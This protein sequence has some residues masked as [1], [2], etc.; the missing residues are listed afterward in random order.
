MYILDLRK[1]IEGDI[2][3]TAQT[4]VISKTIR[5]VSSSDF[6]HAILYVG[7]GSYIHSNGG[8]VHSG[9]TQRLLF[10]KL[11]H[12]QVLRPNNET[13]AEKACIY[14]RTQVGKEYSV[15]DAINSKNPLPKKKES[16][17]QFCSRLV[18]QSYEY[19][20]L[21][22]VDNS[23]YCTPQDI[24]N[25]SDISIVKNILSKASKEEISFSKSENPLQRQAD[26]TNKILKSIRKLTGCDIQSFDELSQFVI[27]NPIYDHGITSIIERSGYLSMWQDEMEKNPWRYNGELFLSM[28]MRIEEKR[29]QASFELKSAHKQ[30]NLYSYNYNMM[31]QNL[32]A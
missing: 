15:K 6:S 8:G 17:R 2:L 7:D 31:Q 3:L 9:N 27:N 24:H 20:G 19:A 12:V 23:S 13:F 14:A 11:K 10:H 29:Q 28:P 32:I 18:A 26:I 16:N 1:L 5:V 4:A 25:S 21:K 22:L 30:L